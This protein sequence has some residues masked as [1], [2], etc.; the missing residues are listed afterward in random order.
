VKGGYRSLTYSH[1]IDPMKPICRTELEGKMCEAPGCEFQHFNQ[2]ALEEGALLMQLGTANPGQNDE[3][4]KLWTDGLREVIRKLRETQ[5]RDPE[6]VAAEISSFR[7]AF[8]KDAS[9]I[10]LVQ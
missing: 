7:R 1:N 8:L 10:V 3:E 4:K 2:M 5:T 9:K 6:V